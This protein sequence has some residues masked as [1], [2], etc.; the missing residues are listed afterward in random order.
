MLTEV[1]MA[2]V[3]EFDPLDRGRRPRR[4]HRKHWLLSKVQLWVPRECK[5]RRD[6]VL[7]RLALI[8]QPKCLRGDSLFHS[9]T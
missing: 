3:C 1:A 5:G 7:V 6:L 8:S 9:C 2:D 4:Y